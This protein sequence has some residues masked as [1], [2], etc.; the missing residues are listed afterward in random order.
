MAALLSGLTDRSIA[1]RKSYARTIG[2]IVKVG[3]S[4]K[5][6]VHVHQEYMHVIV[7]YL[8]I[9]VHVMLYSVYIMYTIIVGC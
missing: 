5:T 4:L 6:L 2:H 8:Y 1:V 3:I 9:V 7:Q